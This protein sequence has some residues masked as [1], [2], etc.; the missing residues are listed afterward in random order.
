MFER[1]DPLEVST[2]GPT[3][4]VSL[5]TDLEINAIC[6]RFED[7]W[8]GGRTPRIEDYHVEGDAIGPRLLAELLAL[9]LEYLW[10]RD[11]RFRPEAETYRRRFPADRGAVDRAFSTFF[12]AYRIP[13][14]RRIGPYELLEELGRGGQGVVY[15][16]RREG[17]VGAAH[18]VALKLILPAR[19]TSHRDV[20]RFVDEVRAM[21]GLNH[22]GILPVFDSGEDRGQPYV[23]MRLV[24]PSLERSLAARGTIG[25]DEAARLVVE[26]ARAVD[27]LHQHGIV[28][29]DLK[30]S[31]I[32]LDGD[33]PLI[34]DFGL[35]RA[36]GDETEPGAIDERRLEGT[37]PYMAPEQVRGEP[38]KA[39][40]L[41]ALG[42][43]LFELVTGRTPFGSGRPALGRILRDEAPGPRQIAPAIPVALDRIVRKCL[44]KDP[45]ERYP[46][47][48]ELAD[49]LERFLRREPLAHTPPET[50]AQG[51]YLWTRRHSELTARLVGLGSIL[52]LTQFNYWLIPRPTDP[53][54][55][56]SVSLVE[57]LWIGTSIAFDG[58][59][60]ARGPRIPLR[61][62]WIVVDVALLTLLLGLLDAAST[63]LVLGYPL[64][65]AA[66][67][68]WDRVRLVWLTTA[69]CMCG[70]AILVIE[71]R[72]WEILWPTRTKTQDP[73]AVLV[74]LLITGYVMAIQVER[75]RDALS[76]VQARR[77]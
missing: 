44:R 30:P 54:Y 59:A 63:S 7:E 17:L 34:T 14:E 33:H 10:R 36:L 38:G 48:A 29:C 13:S 66:S 11:P 15:R 70:Y 20:S 4:E 3:S 46:S 73:N 55:H 72:A 24:G 40:D 47:A 68:L 32:L 19:L 61:A 49:E 22:R 77:P 25:P 5:A 41:Y 26:I 12:E 9:E 23:A 76:A 75:A 71:F 42:A 52:A 56:L 27:Y 58:L 18:S 21:A 16:A 8:R 57:G 62:A 69:L 65:I 51:L 64:L 35:S 6:R 39:S 37:I 28:H 2:V 50:V 43:V 31:N 45:S 60:R 74:I 53:W 1:P 67:G